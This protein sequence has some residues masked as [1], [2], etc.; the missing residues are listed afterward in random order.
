MINN[1]FRDRVSQLEQSEANAR[2]AEVMM[3]DTD[4][5]LRGSLEEVRRSESDLK[6]RVS[7][8]ERLLA[9]KNGDA[10]SGPPSKRIRLSDMVDDNASSS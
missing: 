7:E 1:L 6:R 4:A 10:E 2:Q 5:S 3:R 9:E 8:L